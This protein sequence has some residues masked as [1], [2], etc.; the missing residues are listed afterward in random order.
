MTESKGTRP[1]LA[2]FT[3][4]T[5]PAPIG[6][7]RLARADHDTWYNTGTSWIALYPLWSAVTWAAY[8][9]NGH[10]ALLGDLSGEC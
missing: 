8:G 9:Y 4:A 2:P 3:F 5:L 1:P 6:C 7:G 10:D